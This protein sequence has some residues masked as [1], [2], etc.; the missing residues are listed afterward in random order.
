MI[1]V[2]YCAILIAI[3]I[4]AAIMDYLIVHKEVFEKIL[5]ATSSDSSTLS[6][7]ALVCLFGLCDPFVSML[8]FN[9]AA[10]GKILITSLYWV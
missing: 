7:H 4:S 2:P 8:D 1:E 9:P 6:Q 5:E 10:P 3:F